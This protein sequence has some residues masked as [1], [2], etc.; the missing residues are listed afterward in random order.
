MGSVEGSEKNHYPVKYS[1]SINMNDSDGDSFLN[2]VA[3]Y[4]GDS[5]VLLFRSPIELKEFAQAILHSIPELAENF[6][7]TNPEP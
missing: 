5:T 7:N 2:C 1:W 4:C 6:S 3:V